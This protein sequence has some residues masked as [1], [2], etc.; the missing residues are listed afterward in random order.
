MGLDEFLDGITAPFK[1]VGLIITGIFAIGIIITF[2]FN[3]K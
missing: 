1:T 3:K 2:A